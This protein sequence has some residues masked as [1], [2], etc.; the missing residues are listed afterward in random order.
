MF[1]CRDNKKVHH[2]YLYHNGLLEK[3]VFQNLQ[4]EKC[5]SSEYLATV[6]GRDKCEKSVGF[7]Q[8]LSFSFLININFV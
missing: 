3:E 5:Y 7:I 6:E 1:N 4:F 8:S 2:K